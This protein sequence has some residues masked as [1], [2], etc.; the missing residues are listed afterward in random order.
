ML[1][2]NMDRSDSLMNFL[3]AWMERS[4]GVAMPRIAP[5]PVRPQPSVTTS[6][7][8][9]RSSIGTV[10]SGTIDRIESVVHA[11]TATQPDVAQAIQDFSKVVLAEGLLDDQRKEE[12]LD[13]LAYVV[14]ELRRPQSEANQTVLRK[15]I[16][17]S[18]RLR[19]PLRPWGQLGQL[20]NAH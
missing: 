18:E 4:T 3:G 16:A 13:S 11:A 15:M 1:R 6:I 9:D 8:I 17:G 14:S 19:R 5:P 10:N 2:E 20:S 12:V 7:T